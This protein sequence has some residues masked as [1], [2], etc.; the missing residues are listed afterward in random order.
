MPVPVA[1]V[2][3][4]LQ[5]GSA[6]HLLSTRFEPDGTCDHVAEIGPALTL[7]RSGAVEAG[8]EAGADLVADLLTDLLRAHP[9]DWLFWDE[10]EPGGLLSERN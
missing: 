6:L 9:G 3:L 4:A 2:W 10:F 1:S 8:L 7:E 5:S